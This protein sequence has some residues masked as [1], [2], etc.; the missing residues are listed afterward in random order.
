VS[1]PLLDEAVALERVA[2]KILAESSDREAL[3]LAR[4]CRRLPGA[5]RVLSDEAVASIARSLADATHEAA[6]DEGNELYAALDALAS[7]LGG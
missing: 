1:A 2:E 3:A 6:D 4:L 7:A 5:V